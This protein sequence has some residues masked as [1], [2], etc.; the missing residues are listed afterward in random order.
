M[1]K[2]YKFFTIFFF[3]I[4]SI[5]LVTI[6]NMTKSGNINCTG[7]LQMNSPDEH[8]YLFNGT[9]SVVIRQGTESVISIFGTSISTK[10]SSPVNTHLVNRDITFKVLSR[11]KS[12]F[13][14]SNL[15]TI[16]HPSDSMTEAEAS[17]LIFDMFDLE[18]NR[19]TVRRYLNAFVFGDVPLPLFI[20]LKKR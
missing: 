17:G 5:I 11:K 3:V 15:K 9:I 10:Q 16:A 13:Y 2:K 6:S 18:H 20:C 7:T 1:N 14:I 4:L 19:L 12:D 8:E